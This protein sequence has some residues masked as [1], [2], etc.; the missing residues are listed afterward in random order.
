M[1]TLSIEQVLT[2]LCYDEEDLSHPTIID[3]QKLSTIAGLCCIQFRAKQ[4]YVC[5]L[6]C[7]Y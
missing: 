3:L 7:I 6:E 1:K 4:R 2:T 5:S